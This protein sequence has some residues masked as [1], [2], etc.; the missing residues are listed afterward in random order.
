M[1]IGKS[2]ENFKDRKPKYFNYNKY[3]HMAKECQV[4]KKEREIRTYFKCDKKG[5]IAKDCKGKQMIK[6]QKVQA[7]A[8][9]E[10]NKSKQCF[11]KDLE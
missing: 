6:K 4:E 11:D 7:E 2:N 9:D 3:G 8:D 1:D 10:D 5:Y